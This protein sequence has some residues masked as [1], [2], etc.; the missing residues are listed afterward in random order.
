MKKSFKGILSTFLSEDV[1]RRFLVPTFSVVELLPFKT[2]REA[3]DEAANKVIE[4]HWRSGRWR[5]YFEL[6]AA[7]LAFGARDLLV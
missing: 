5:S 2:I 7:R 4:I 1:G 6:S 3:A